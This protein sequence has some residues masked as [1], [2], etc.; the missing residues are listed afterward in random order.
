MMKPNTNTGTDIDANEAAT[1]YTVYILRCEDGS[2]YTGITTDLDRRLQEH[3]SRGPK[4]ARYTRT[5]PVVGVEATWHAPDRASASAMEH[6]IKQLTRAQKLAL[7]ADSQGPAT[8]SNPGA[9]RHRAVGDRPRP[10]ATREEPQATPHSSHEADALAI[11]S[12]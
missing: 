3:E 4:A 10:D 5:H 6:R 8:W 9:P 7:I 2:L 11:F 12:T 1:T